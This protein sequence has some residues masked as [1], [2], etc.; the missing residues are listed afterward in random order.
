[1]DVNTFLGFGLILHVTCYV[2]YNICIK[3]TDL[4][5]ITSIITCIE[6]DVQ[7][8]AISLPSN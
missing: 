5:K 3:L 2:L 7:S 6:S 4:E 8:P 1:M